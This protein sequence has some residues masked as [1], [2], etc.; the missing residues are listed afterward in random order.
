MLLPRV[1]TAVFGI[2][3]ILIAVRLGG[4]SFLLLVFGVSLFCLYETFSLFAKIGVKPRSMFGY[5][6]A[7]F[8][9]I[10]FIM[11]SYAEPKYAPLLKNPAAAGLGITL[12]MVILSAIELFYLKTRS[13]LSSAVTLFSIIF[14][15]WPLAHLVL[16]RDLVPLGQEW[17]VFLFVTI[18]IS[19]T[20]A[21]LVGH[22][23]GRNKLAPRVSPKKTIEGFFGGILGGMLSGSVLWVLFFRSEGISYSEMAL[24]GGAGIGV[25]AQLSDLA[26]SVLK[27]EAKVKDSSDALPGHGGFLDRF[28][29]FILTTPLLY[30]YVILRF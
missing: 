30:Y 1:L 25:V 2:P 28:D 11:P 29:S 4:I 12:T 23:I 7:V 18:W 16:L 5:P 26:E 19:D 20:A 8:L 15:C 13:F 10:V 3:I 6:L 24:L 14:V 27:R 22:A 21:Y 9:F 17:C